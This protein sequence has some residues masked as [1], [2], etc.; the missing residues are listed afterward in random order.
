MIW[1]KIHSPAAFYTDILNCD[2]SLFFDYGVLTKGKE[3][4]ETELK[5]FKDEWG[6]NPEFNERE[7]NSWAGYEK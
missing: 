2:F 5:L 1:Y 7:G 3:K 4:L 6:K